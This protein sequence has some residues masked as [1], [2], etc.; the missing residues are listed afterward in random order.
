MAES[1]SFIHS[2]IVSLFSL[3]E[4]L[5]PGIEKVAGIY[6]DG[7]VHEIRIISRKRDK[8]IDTDFTNI[9]EK[10]EN[11]VRIQKFRSSSQAFSW[12]R[13]EDIPFELSPYSGET[14]NLF[15][16]LE[17]VVLV[18]RYRSEAD[19]LYDLLFLYLNP[20]LSN[21]GI[22]RPEKVLS[23]EDKGMI[24]HILYHYFRS[25][26]GINRY[27]REV[28]GSL[29]H[30]VRSLVRQNESIREDAVQTLAN[31]GD[32][33]VSLCQQYLQELSEERDVTYVLSK[34]AEE[35]IREFKGNV[36]HLS[37]IIRNAAA[38]TENLIA[39]RYHETMIIEPYSLNFDDYQLTSLPEAEVKKIDSRES[40]A[41]QLLDK[42]EKA[43]ISLKA[44]NHS[45]T[46]VNIG[47]SLPQPITAP[48]ITDALKKNRKQLLMVLKK[49]PEKW[50]TI[51]NDFKPLRNIMKGQDDANA[52]QEIA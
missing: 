24:G 30:S 27:N 46:S 6:F 5:L 52:Q 37:S 40:K 28:L 32:S 12:I 29:Q 2:D 47:Q 43:A 34:E 50:D 26:I 38:F 48:A 41:V 31:Y 23:D 20:S 1:F 16:E 15:S 10:R 18:L 33:M 36:R 3:Q 9:L 44:R 4:I 19:S 49:Y 13:K 17:K 45:L 7:A 42:F 11:L 21:Y 14:P 22:N 25:I 35:R 39:G 51:R 8:A